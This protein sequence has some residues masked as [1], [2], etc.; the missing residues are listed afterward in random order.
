MSLSLCPTLRKVF[1]NYVDFDPRDPEHLEAFRML[2]LEDTARQ[3]P[4]LRFN[5]TEQYTDV[6]SMM[7]VEVGRAHVDH[8]NRLISVLEQLDTKTS[9]RLRTLLEA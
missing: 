3:H 1:R 6:R 4:T 8:V 9:S 7:M 5:L 2:C